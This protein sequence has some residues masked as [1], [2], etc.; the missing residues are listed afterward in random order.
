LSRRV[1]IYRGQAGINLRARQ[2]VIV[3]KEKSPS[4][5][6]CQRGRTKGMFSEYDASLTPPASVQLPD[7]L[8]LDKKISFLNWKRLVPQ[9]QKVDRAAD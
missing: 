4:I 6:L 8:D 9:L 5:P 7:F 2:Q 1:P 3:L